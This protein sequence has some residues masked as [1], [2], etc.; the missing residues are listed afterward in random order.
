MTTKLRK[1]FNQDGSFS[2]QHYGLV[3]NIWINPISGGD[4][5]CCWDRKIDPLFISEINYITHL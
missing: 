5:G 4:W 3:D 1:N 2:S